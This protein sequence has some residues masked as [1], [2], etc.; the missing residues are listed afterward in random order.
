[1]TPRATLQE[2][3]DLAQVSLGTA[4]R[5]LAGRGRVAEATRRR[6]REAAE[7]LSFA[8]N[9]AASN[10]RRSRAGSVGLW[11][12]PQLRFMDY[13]M[14][15]TF[16]LSE[17]L[18]ADEISLS[19]IPH[20]LRPADVSR[21]HVD[22]F[23]MSDVVAGDPLA[24][25]VL[26]S[27][28]PVITSEVVP[29]GM[30]APTGSV[31]TDHAGAMRDA[32]ERLR[33]GGARSI[34]IL[35]PDIGQSWAEAA[36]AG[37]ASW[38]EAA[39]VRVSFVTL[40]E[41]PV[42]ADLHRLVARVLSTTDDVDAIVCAADGVAVGVLTALHDLGI[43]VPERVQ[44]VSHVDSAAMPIVLPPIAAVDLRPREAGALTGRM[45]LAELDGTAG[46]TH[47]QELPLEFHARASLRP[48]TDATASTP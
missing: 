4:S 17:A 26:E 30:P 18:G 40:T 45:L 34:V 3:A 48:E 16:G 1:M 38:A 32:L 41:V 37:A 44:L 22:G 7:S 43:A 29:A 28:K 11:L 8:P 42:A 36:H 15:F 21:L 46:D 9:T 2:V 13:Y 25:A 12:P 35:I 39:P 6:V 5:A 20:S 14:N 24:R 19:L 47:V 23:V 31:V 33:R 27:G 10:F